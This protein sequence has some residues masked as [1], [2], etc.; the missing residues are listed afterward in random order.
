MTPGDQLTLTVEKPAAEA[1]PVEEDPTEP[2][3]KPVR[4]RKKKAPAT[5][6][7]S[8]GGSISVPNVEGKDHQLAQDTMQ[9]AGLYILNEK[10][11]SGQDRALVLDR[12]WTVQSQEPAAGTKVSEDQEI[13]LCSVKDGE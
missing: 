13:T 10:D 7:D 1:P 2:S 9:G 8:G 5:A 12:N 4:K 11:C 3:E 6:S